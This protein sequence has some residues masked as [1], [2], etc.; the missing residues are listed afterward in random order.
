MLILQGV[1]RSGTSLLFRILRQ[2]PD[3]R[4][5]YEP[6]HPNLLNHVRESDT[7]RPKH[8][9]SFLYREYKRIPNPLEDY[10]EVD[11]ASKHSHLNSHTKASTLSSY[12]QVLVASAHRVVLQF[13]RA[14]WMSQWLHATFPDSYFVHLVRD[15]RSVVWSQLTTSSGDRVRMD[16]PLVGRLFPFSS[17]DLRQVFSRHAYFGA[18]HL[19]EYFERGC[20]IFEQAGDDEV[21]RQILKRLQVTRTARPF[22]KAL[23]LWGAQVEACHNQAQSA[24]GTRYLLLRYEEFCEAPVEHLESIYALQDRRLPARVRR[25]AQKSVNEGPSRRWKKT[26]MAE[27]YFREGIQRAQIADLMRDIGYNLS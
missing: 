12:L 3:Q 19:D 25:Y 11:L 8:E 6:L 20:H 15:P 16:W 10:F 4:S 22:V 14:F 7:R 27:E 18:Y 9:K 17:T 13:N 1:F 2:D 5:Y 24:F 26:P 21:L 23:S